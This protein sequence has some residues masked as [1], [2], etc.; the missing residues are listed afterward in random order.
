MQSYIV[1]MSAS[2]T[3][4]EYTVTL[5]VIDSF[6]TQR[7]QLHHEALDGSRSIAYQVTNDEGSHFERDA[8]INWAKRLVSNLKPLTPFFC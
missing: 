4:P 8:A 5:Q 2:G 1:K 7:V 6:G 3:Y